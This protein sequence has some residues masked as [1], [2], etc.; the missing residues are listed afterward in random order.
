MWI[1]NTRAIIKTLILLFGTACLLVISLSVSVQLILPDRAF[2][3]FKQTPSGVNAFVFG[4]SRL[5]L[6]R[7]RLKYGA[8][9]PKMNHFG[10]MHQWTRILLDRDNPAKAIVESQFS[11][12]NSPGRSVHLQFMDQIKSRKLFGIQLMSFEFEHEDIDAIEIPLLYVEMILLLPALFAIRSGFVSLRNAVRSGYGFCGECGYDLRQS[13]ERCP[14]CGNAR[15][16][17]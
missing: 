7:N 5:V 15:K 8:S 4:P 11:M 14:E 10:Q 9:W 13:P 1:F 6:L 12:H 2:G 3:V 17:P 16:K